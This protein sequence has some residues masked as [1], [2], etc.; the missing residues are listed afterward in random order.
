VHLCTSA[1][2][3]A[4]AVHHLCTLHLLHLLC[5]CSLHL[6]TSYGAP[7][8]SSLA[9]Q[10]ATNVIA[11]PQHTLSTSAPPYLLHLCT[12]FCTSALCTLHSAL[13]TLHSAPSPSPSPAQLH[14]CATCTI[15]PHPQQ[16][17]TQHLSTSMII[18]ICTSAPH[19]PTLH[20]AHAQSP[21]LNL[22]TY[23]APQHFHISASLH[24]HK[25]HLLIL[26]STACY[27][28]LQHLHI[29]TPVPAP[30]TL[31]LC[32]VIC[33]DAPPLHFCTFAHPS[34]HLL[35]PITSAPLNLNTY[36]AYCF[37]FSATA[38][39]SISAPSPPLLDLLCT[40]APLLHPHLQLQLHLCT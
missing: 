34:L 30:A 9:P 19:A 23:S 26:T 13:C 3:S 37:S 24:L 39:Y 18:A 12:K 38:P 8:Q 22:S 33:S 10:S 32:T 1:S 6:C 40:S 11:E 25:S 28:A 16:L 35:A 2:A 36:S 20:M 15:P 17:T 5:T 4:P 27:S 7:T 14:L 29:G 31:H 21:L